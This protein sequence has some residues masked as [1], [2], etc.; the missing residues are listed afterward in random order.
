MFDRRAYTIDVLRALANFTAR[1]KPGEYS[2]APYDTVKR[3]A[4]GYPI[5][6]QN[7]DELDK[8]DDIDDAECLDQLDQLI[9]PINEIWSGPLEWL[10]KDPR[11]DR[12]WKRV[13][14]FA[15]EGVAL[16]ESLPAPKKRRRV[17]QLDLPVEFYSR[18]RVDNPPTP[19]EEQEE[20]DGFTRNDLNWSSLRDDLMVVLGYHGIVGPD[21]PA[22]NPHFFLADD[23][24]NEE[25]YHYSEVYNPDAF[26]LDWLRDVTKK[27]SEFAG[28]GLA[29][30]NLR[31]AYMLIF[32][33]KL[34]VTGAPFKGHTDVARVLE[35]AKTLV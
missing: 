24:Y 10:Q 27:L 5:Y 25:R 18:N 15:A 8:L 4:T 2:S 35:T 28:W 33:D 21:E 22:D 3:V 6:R 20:G 1:T 26:T 19:E 11:T 9:S 13:K 12:T 34:M 7:Y 29:V 31:G 16:L 30:K 23:R 14:K 17:S 32:A